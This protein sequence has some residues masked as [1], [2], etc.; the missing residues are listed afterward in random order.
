[1]SAST[2]N[3]HP[4]SQTITANTNA[5]RNPPISNPDRRL[6]A[7]ITIRMVIIS[8]TNPKVRKLRGRVRRR[9]IAPTVPLSNA[10]T[11]ATIIA[12]QKVSTST[13]GKT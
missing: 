8:E 11:T 12:H 3:N 9:N 6:L 4:I 5:F 2:P 10:I 13:P 1:L 7:N